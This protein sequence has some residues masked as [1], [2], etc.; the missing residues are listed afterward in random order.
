M[1][2]KIEQLSNH[3]VWNNSDMYD[4]NNP[5]T[6]SPLIEML[7]YI[8]IVITLLIII[9]LIFAFAFRAYRKRKSSNNDIS[10]Q[11][12]TIHCVMSSFVGTVLLIVTIGLL[13]LTLKIPSDVSQ[14][15][16]S[17]AYEKIDGQT[18]IENVKEVKGKKVLT[19]NIDGQERK[20]IM[21]KQEDVSKGDTIKIKQEHQTLVQNQVLKYHSS[22]IPDLNNENEIHQNDD[23]YKISIEKMK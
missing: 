3:D 7:Y 21:N 9:S 5:F 13:V 4:S 23:N 15:K 12:Y 8:S 20:V 10:K 1:R 6:A 19:I 2:R 11:F 16:Q 18:E 14:I 17:F 22:L